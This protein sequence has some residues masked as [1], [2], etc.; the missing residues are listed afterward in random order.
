MG[1]NLKGYE[2][3]IENLSKSFGNLE[4]LKDINITIPQ[5]QFVAVVGHSGCGKSTLLRIIEGLDVPTTGDIT[6]NNK[7]VNGVDSNVRFIFQDARLLPWKSVLNNV[8]IGT[9]DKDKKKAEEALSHVGLFERKKAW[10]GILSGGQ[11]QRVS[12]ARA[13]SGE[14]S[15]L[16]LDE[17]LGALDA[18]TRLEMQTLIEG[19]WKEQGFTAILVTHDVSEAV[20]LADRVIVIDEHSIKID[21]EITLPRPRTKNNDSSYFEQKILS[22]LMRGEDKDADFTI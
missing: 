19:L 16:L 10:P 20:K 17:P 14:P 4:I 21:L 15:V 18:L 13:L 3:K 12:L 8:L 6:V 5:G 9:K 11:K 7:K 2:I 1:E 22:Y